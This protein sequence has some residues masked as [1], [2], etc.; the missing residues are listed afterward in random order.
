MWQSLH[1][2][3]LNGFNSR[4]SGGLMR[5]SRAWKEKP[6]RAISFFNRYVYWGSVMSKKEIDQKLQLMFETA[7]E[8]SN[9]PIPVVKN[10]AEIITG[11]LQELMVTVIDHD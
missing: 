6:F 3:A 2:K 11:P 7:R 8:L 10:R 5:E 4:G 9:A 1:L